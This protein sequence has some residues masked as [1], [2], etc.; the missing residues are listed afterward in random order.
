MSESVTTMKDMYTMLR[1]WSLI[2]MGDP[3]RPKMSRFEERRY[4]VWQRRF[5]KTVRA[6]K[7]RPAS[8]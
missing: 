4:V 5:K 8:L 1:N 2:A 3:N 6:S 7:R